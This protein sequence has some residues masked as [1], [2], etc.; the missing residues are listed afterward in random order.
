[1]YGPQFGWVGAGHEVNSNKFLGICT[2]TSPLGLRKGDVLIGRKSERFYTG[3]GFGHHYQTGATN[4][5][6]NGTAIP[7]EILEIA[8]VDREL[9]TKEKRECNLLQ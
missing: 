6:W 8:V 7:S 3:W 9:A 2:M 5:A 4:M 1:V